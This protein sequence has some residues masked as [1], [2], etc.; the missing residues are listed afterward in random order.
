MRKV[1]LLCIMSLAAIGCW[2]DDGFTV[3]PLT[4]SEGQTGTLVINLNQATSGK[5]C[6]FQFDFYLPEGVEVASETNSN[7]SL[8]YSNS[9]T[10]SDR[11]NN[12]RI[13]FMQKNGFWRIMVFN[14]GGGSSSVFSGTEGPI[15]NVKVT[16]NS[17]FALGEKTG[18][19][20]NIVLTIT[21]DLTSSYMPSD[22]PYT[23]TGVEPSYML[24]DVNDDG[25]VD[26][27]DFIATLRYTL[28]QVPSVFIEEAAD[29]NQDGTIDNADAI[30]ILRMTIN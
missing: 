4:L 28:G 30:K 18:Y 22:F 15:L 26:N 3:D 23:I 13:S 12:H 7:G 2:A 6:A 20:K 16:T 29:V 17:Q 27:A 24:G 5:Y 21:E 11:I 1:Y 19:V 9:F 14:P 10:L 25:V 8:N